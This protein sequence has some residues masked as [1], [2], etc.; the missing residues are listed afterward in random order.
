MAI[1]KCGCNNDGDAAKFQDN[2]YGVGHRVHTPDKDSENFTCT[3]CGN[4]SSKGA[5][6]IVSK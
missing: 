3:I 5:K 4:K 1:I 2:K 6:K